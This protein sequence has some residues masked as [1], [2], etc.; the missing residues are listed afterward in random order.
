VS[1]VNLSSAPPGSGQHPVHPPVVQCPWDARFQPNLLVPVGSRVLCSWGRGR[2]SRHCTQSLPAPVAAAQ[3]KRRSRRS[4]R[5]V[6]SRTARA[7]WSFCGRFWTH[8]RSA[9]SLPWRCVD[10]YVI[11]SRIFFIWSGLELGEWNPRVTLPCQ[12]ASSSEPL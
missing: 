9:A 6:W 1:C 3:T 8:L 12:R 2:N 5:R 11:Y 10:S 7:T 4:I